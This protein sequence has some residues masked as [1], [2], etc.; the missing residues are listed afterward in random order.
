LS[1]AE[2][3]AQIHL[4]EGTVRNYISAIFG[5]LQANDR[6]QAVVMALRYGLID[7]RDR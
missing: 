4:S 2:I 5:M 6:T 1:N 7:L 3:G